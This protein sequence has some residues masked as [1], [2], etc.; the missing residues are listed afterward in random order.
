MRQIAYLATLLVAIFLGLSI[1]QNGVGGIMDGFDGLIGDG[2]DAP[3]PDPLVLFIGEDNLTEADVPLNNMTV[4]QKPDG[5]LV[6]TGKLGDVRVNI[7]E[8]MQVNP[9]YIARAGI[10][11]GYILEN[12]P[13]TLVLFTVR[14]RV[15]E[16]KGFSERKAVY[17]RDLVRVLRGE[18]VPITKQAVEI[19]YSDSSAKGVTLCGTVR[20]TGERE[21]WF[22]RMNRGRLTVLV[23]QEG[24]CA[25]GPDQVK[26]ALGIA[27]RMLAGNNN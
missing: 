9:R 7:P 13:R 8:G 6:M 1:A 2:K 4:T 27:A 22:G 26:D 24:T 20:E 10:T 12:E 3:P 16:R 15:I 5:N 25:D 19:I 11:G 17:E 21:M 23:V 18:R 14:R